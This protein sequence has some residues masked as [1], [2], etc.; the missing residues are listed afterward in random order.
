MYT[1][2]LPCLIKKFK[3]ITRRF[4]NS[5]GDSQKSKGRPKYSNWPS[6]VAKEKYLVWLNFNL[7]KTIFEVE[8]YKNRFTAKMR[9]SSIIGKG[10][11]CFTLSL[12]GRRSTHNLN[13][14]FFFFT[15]TTRAQYGDVL[16]IIIF[17][18]NRSS[19]ISLTCNFS[20]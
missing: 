3:I 19:V 5:A 10:Y 18:D 9:Q 16:T 11:F 7:M 15:G 17:L 14:P 4:W 2:T 20:L 12:S 6:G 8:E 13:V 1:L